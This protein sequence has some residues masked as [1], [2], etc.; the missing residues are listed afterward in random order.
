MFKHHACGLE[1]AKS[2]GRRRDEEEWQPARY[3]C[4]D[5]ESN[6]PFLSKLHKETQSMDH[7]K[8]CDAKERGIVTTNRRNWGP[9]ARRS[10]V[11]M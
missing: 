4:S 11:S 5:Y 1:V 6:L 9:R 7:L 10:P 2:D 3:T 8:V